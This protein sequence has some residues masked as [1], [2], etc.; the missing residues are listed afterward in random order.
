MAAAAHFGQ[1]FEVPRVCAMSSWSR[2]A[3]EHP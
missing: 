2:T 3:L 1:D